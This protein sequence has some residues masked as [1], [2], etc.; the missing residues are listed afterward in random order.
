MVKCL[1]EVISCLPSWFFI[2][3]N[4]YWSFI[5]LNFK[6]DCILLLWLILRLR[7]LLFDL[8][9]A[10]SQRLKCIYSKA[11]FL[12]LN[13]CR[14][15][16]KFSHFSKIAFKIFSI[17]KSVSCSSAPETYIRLKSS[18]YSFANSTI[19]TRIV[20]ALPPLMIKFRVLIFRY[21]IFTFRFSKF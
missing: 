14:L 21:N 7:C 11:N 4:D 15:K 3:Y 1:N 9:Y 18:T 17:T 13:F 19:W 8:T 10:F 12:A 16:N 5:W 20:S 6:C 2:N